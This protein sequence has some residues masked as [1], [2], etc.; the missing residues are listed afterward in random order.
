MNTVLNIDVCPSLNPSVYW[1]TIS[2][3]PQL[4]QD[5]VNLVMI[6]MISPAMWKNTK[7][8]KMWQKWHP[9]DA[10]MQQT[11]FQLHSSIWLPCLNSQGAGGKLVWIL[12]I[13]YPTQCRFEIHCGY[14]ISLNAENKQ[15]KCTQIAFISLRWHETKSPSY[16]MVLEWMAAA[17]LGRMLLAGG[18]HKKPGR[19]SVKGCCKPLYLSQWQDIGRV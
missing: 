4:V 2:S 9:D 10:I 15:R 14:Q 17:V 18:S 5:L 12:I 3:P 6:H 19:H 11:F 13:T 7:H 1:A 8:Q 16:W